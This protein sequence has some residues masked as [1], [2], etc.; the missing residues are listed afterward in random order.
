METL[1]D[2]NFVHPNK[3]KSRPD[4][5][6]KPSKMSQEAKDTAAARM[7]EYNPMKDP[8]I[9]DRMIASYKRTCALENYVHPN[10]GRERPDAKDRMLSD[11]NPMKDPE[12]ARL[13]WA[14]AKETMRKKGGLSEGQRKLYEYLD[15]MG[16]KYEPECFFQLDQSDYS[17]IFADAYL[18]DF[19]IIIEYDGYSDHYSEE[20]IKRDHKRDDY[21]DKLFQI[22]V[23]RLDT[24]SIFAKDI[25]KTILKAI[26]ELKVVSSPKNIYIGKTREILINAN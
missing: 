11:T 4:L 17:Y 3:G 12:T 2:P 26:D 19:N 20:G 16:F 7:K 10:K 5:L 14:K 8:E 15:S 23:I 1:N 25:D 22:S 6:G 9:K 13:V 24:S 18:P 21:V